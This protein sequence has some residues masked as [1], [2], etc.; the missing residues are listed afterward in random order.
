M[1]DFGKEHL[2]ACDHLKKSD[3]HMSKAISIVEGSDDKVLWQQA[4]TDYLATLVKSITSQMLSIHAAKAIFNRM[5][6]RISN[7]FNYDSILSIS[8]AEWKEIGM[9]KNKTKTIQSLAQSISEKKLS[10]DS[11]V[12]K[13]SQEIHETLVSY[14]GIGPWTSQMF[15]IFQ[16]RDI[17]I[18]PI[19]DAGIWQGAKI[20][21]KLKDYPDKNWFKTKQKLWNPYCSIAS[22]YLWKILHLKKSY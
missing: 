2:Q 14:T 8:E 21:Y 18:L 17:N 7:K 15:L 5:S 13:S 20:I 16:I 10:L 22:L 4:N 6:L 9:S 3:L 11:L 19:Q 12:L 1:R